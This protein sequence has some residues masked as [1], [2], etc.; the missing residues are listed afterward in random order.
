MDARPVASH[1]ARA[2]Y[3]PTARVRY[4]DITYGRA[5][6]RSYY[7]HVADEQAPLHHLR[8]TH[9]ELERLRW[10]HGDGVDLEMARRMLADVLRQ[11]PTEEPRWIPYSNWSP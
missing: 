4:I 5:P 7:V 3:G 2:V 1:L 11:P 10:E 8:I 6:G 9:E